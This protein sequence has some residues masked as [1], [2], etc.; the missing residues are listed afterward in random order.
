MIPPSGNGGKGKSPTMENPAK[1]NFMVAGL[2]VPLL[3]A[4][5]VGLAAAGQTAQKG[6]SLPPRPGTV[7]R[8]TVK[9]V[10]Y[11]ALS[12]AATV[13][14]RPTSLGAGTMGQ[15]EISPAGSAVR[16]HA[17]FANLPPAAH[18]G[19]GYLTYVLW[20]VTPEGRTSNLGEVDRVGT[21]GRIDAKVGSKVFGLIVTAEPYFAVSQPDNAVVLEAD[22]AADRRVLEATCELLSPSVGTERPADHA[23]MAADP[24]GP[25][26]LDE[27]RR[28]IATAREAGA[29]RYAPDT[30]QTAEQLLQL[31][32]GQQER[33]VPRK[34]VEE[35]ASEATLIAEDAR[36]LTAS[37]QARERQATAESGSSP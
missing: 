27:A 8:R 26:L 28:A 32:E 7:R 31:A 11:S 5:L 21:D 2:A 18:L 12:A 19:A 20:G 16:I 6:F 15:A 36:A 3:A 30:L 37:R 13:T 22:V 35:T 25:L 34:T 9:V 33:G 14:F 4:A 23:P 24:T 10:D 1:T 29:S 17:L